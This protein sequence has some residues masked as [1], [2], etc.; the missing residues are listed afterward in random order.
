MSKKELL[1]DVR[2]L[3]HAIFGTDLASAKNHGAAPGW[4]LSGG[5][6]FFSA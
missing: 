1:E 4:D 2:E 3:I 5:V 6:G